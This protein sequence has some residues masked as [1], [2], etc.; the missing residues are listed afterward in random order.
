M[1]E[2][3]PAATRRIPALDL[4]RL[5]AALSVVLFH[6]SFRGWAADGYTTVHLPGLLPWV[7]YAGRGVS[8]FF[9]ISGFVIAYSAAGRSTG[10]FAVAR[11]ARLYPGFLIC[12]TLTFAVTVL[13][14]MPRFQA[15]MTQWLANLLIVSPALGQ[16]YMDGAYW[17]IV[18]EVTFYAWMALLIATGLFPRYL[19]EIVAMWLA[20]SLAN[21]LFMHVGAA[22]RLLLTDSS[23]FFAAG[24]MLYEIYFGKSDG[25]S[26]MLLL[27]AT[28]IAAEQ[29]VEA[30]VWTRGHFGV[31]LSD[32]VLAAIAVGSV[33]LV[34]LGALPRRLPLPSAL[35]IALGGLT[36]PLY[37][38]HQHI[39]Y[40][41]LNRLDG[42]A[43]PGTLV[44]GVIVIM[45]V[46]SWTIWRFAE[47][48]AQRFTKRALAAMA[49]RM[50]AQAPER[51]TGAA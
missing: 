23:G 34:G 28:L 29:A 49:N 43:A 14:G 19:R 37:L 20:L 45:L 30:A 7:K 27:A 9:V 12:M 4:L 31:T 13:F 33:V 8:L 51:A 50:G 22:D 16:P 40:I 17:S 5:F 10:Q 26:W 35:V 2:P 48:P 18:C 47:L 1:S 25:V 21:M 39:G 15:S 24:L 42:I 41:I 3:Q 32:P 11:I 6:Y 44:A 36:Y 46:I 38:L